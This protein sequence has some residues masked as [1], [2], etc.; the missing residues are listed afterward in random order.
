MGI[1]RAFAPGDWVASFTGQKGLVLSLEAY[2]QA[3][4][5]LREGRRPGH[6]FAPGCCPKPDYLVQVPVL[7][8]DG[9]YDVM[10]ALNLKRWN[11][12]SREEQSRIQGLL[13]ALT[14]QPADQPG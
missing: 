7:F 2:A 9:T 1:K 13:T 11:D 4:G 10:R 8:E 5:R 14:E 3:G 6:Y 12:A